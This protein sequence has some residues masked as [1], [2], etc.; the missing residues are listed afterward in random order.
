MNLKNFFLVLWKEKSIITG[1]II[2]VTVVTLFLGLFKAPSFQTYLNVEV[3]RVNRPSTE[4]YQYDEY[5][6]IQAANLVTDTVQSWLK[7]K[8][9]GGESLAK[10]DFDAKQYEQWDSFLKSRK[11]SFQ[12][13]ELEITTNDR[14]TTS[15]LAKIVKTTIESRVANLNL[16]SEGQPAFKADIEVGPVEQKMVNFTFLFLAS[17]CGGLLLGIFLALIFFYWEK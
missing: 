12:N 4:D 10:A 15:Q 8:S 7:G 9:F 6:A 16:N 13:L 14:K 17:L 2:L 5:Y 11:L 1:V 3:K